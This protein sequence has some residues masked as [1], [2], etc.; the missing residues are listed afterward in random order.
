MKKVCTY[1]VL[2]AFISALAASSVLRQQRLAS[3][4]IRLHILANSDSAADQQTKL[5]VRDALLPEIESLTAA[6]ASRE[7]AEAVLAEHAAALGRTAARTAGERVTVCLSPERYPT[8]RYGAFSLPAGE[9]LSLRVGIGEEAGKNWWCTA[10][11]SVCT[12]ATAA[13]FE[14]VA[15][16]G[17]LSGSDLRMMAEEEPDI[18][19]RYLVLELI[20]RLRMRF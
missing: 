16:S 20:S 17:G 1:L 6:C 7:E 18:K 14:S 12:A 15:V 5:A 10:F 2:L 11:P 9:Y 4:L 13:E 8:R 19:V 3:R